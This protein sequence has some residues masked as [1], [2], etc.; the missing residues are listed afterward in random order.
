MTDI[1]TEMD[2]TMD[3]ADLHHHPSHQ[4]MSNQSQ[5]ITHQSQSIM[6]QNPSIMSL[7]AQIVAMKSR[8]MHLS[9]MVMFQ[10]VTSGIKSVT[11]TSGTQS[12]TKLNTKK[13]SRP[14]Q[15]S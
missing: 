3:D 11:S 2:M 7:F 8:L 4:S 9:L 10:P 14:K 12:G 15:N 13:E 5:S 1:S 6:S